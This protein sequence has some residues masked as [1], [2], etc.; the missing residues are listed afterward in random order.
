MN[1]E[2][3]LQGSWKRRRNNKKRG[4]INLLGQ[5]SIF[6]LIGLECLPEKIWRN[7]EKVRRRR[8]RKRSDSL[9]NS[10]YNQV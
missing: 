9:L 8:E 7:R 4:L 6:K 3:R 1:K 10:N 5:Q 2:Q